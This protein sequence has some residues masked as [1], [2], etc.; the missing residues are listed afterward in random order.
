MDEAMKKKVDE[1]MES[2]DDMLESCRSVKG[3]QFVDVAATIFEVQQ[4]LVVV[5]A[6]RNAKDA[7]TAQGYM[8]GAARILANIVSRV[9]SGMSDADKKEASNMGDQMFNR[10]LELEAQIFGN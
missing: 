5:A 3:G 1:M 9:A 10:K 2:I 6:I 8:E 4:V 7:S